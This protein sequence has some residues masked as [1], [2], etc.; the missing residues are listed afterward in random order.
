MTIS[1]VAM[2]TPERLK[3]I[4]AL[5][6]K[7]GPLAN[8]W[9]DQSEPILNAML[10]CSPRL[11]HGRRRCGTVLAISPRACM[12]TLIAYFAT[13]RNR[14]VELTTSQTA[15]GCWRTDGNHD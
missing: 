7:D 9:R 8:A 1:R 11:R 14:T 5:I 12:E 13:V 4:E 10:T 2:M 15:P 3:E 6:G